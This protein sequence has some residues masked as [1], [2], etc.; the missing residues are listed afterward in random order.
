MKE[1]L[2]IREIRSGLLG[3]E[4]SAREL[5]D[6]YIS[7]SDEKNDLNAFITK[8]HDLARQQADRV[9]SM[10]SAKEEVP[11]LAGVPVGV[12]DN[13]LVEGEKC[14]AASK[15]L[16]DYVA[17]ENA[18]VID[19]I[20]SSGGVIMGKTNLDEFAMGA[21]TENS[22]FG[23]SRNPHDT[24]RVPGGS[25]GGSAVAVASNQCSVSLGSDTGG[26]IRQPASY[27]GVVGFKPTYGTVSRYGLIP[28]A[29]SLDQIG[30][31]AKN[32]EDAEELFN[33]IS[34]RDLKDATSVDYTHAMSESLPLKGM[35]VGVVNEHLSDGVD[36]EVKGVILKRLQDMEREG[37]T[38]VE[39]SL[40]S[41]EYA[42]AA[43][44][45][46]NTS[47]ASSNLAR[48]DGIRYGGV[49]G[50]KGYDEVRGEGFGDE[51]KRRI[52]LGSYALSAGH[53]D[54]YYVKAQKIRELLKRDLQNAF[55]K[56]D[57]LAG[58]VTPVLPFKIGER[59]DNPL[60]MY[61]VDAFTV[62]VNLTGYP[63]ISLP[64][65]SSSE[66]LPVGLQLIAPA[67]QDRRLFA[68]GKT[69]ESLA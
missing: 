67:F 34:G 21:S 19:R 5:V 33:V 51:P 11:V 24:D 54:A 63:A 59:I 16:E 66:G 22:Y 41:V 38:L 7:R 12:K 40:P 9:D 42:L 14:T 32:V 4:F 15:M 1:A 49:K 56:V 26:S 30:P 65:G 17:P 10:I 13:M 37:A 52:M 62:P 25:S 36:S 47:E 60:Q 18:T 6:S 39:L 27:C 46:V 68:A 28:L 35:K 20:L 31:F 8:T 23:V 44:Y 3:G 58:P 64:A 61:L 55:Q 2:S 48:Y 69:I 53:Y 50:D 45:I 43:Y 29:S 57:L